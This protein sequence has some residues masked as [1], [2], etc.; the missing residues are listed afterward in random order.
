VAKPAAAFFDVAFELLDTADRGSTLIVGDSLS[1][2]MRG[3]ADYGLATCW[4]NPHRRT[5]P[6]AAGID[7]E[8]ERL[9]QL[10]GIVGA[11]RRT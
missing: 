3:G 1:A 7:H 5:A 6:S 11:G 10:P 8:V 9:D 2:D 4:Y